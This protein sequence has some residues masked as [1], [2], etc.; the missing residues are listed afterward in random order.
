MRNVL[1][2]VVAAYAVMVSASLAN[3][4]LVNFEALARD[5]TAWS[6]NVI[7]GEFPEQYGSLRLSETSSFQQNS[8]PPLTTSTSLNGS[9]AGLASLTL[10]NFELAASGYFVSRSSGLNIP[11]TL[12]VLGDISGI[13]DQSGLIPDFFVVDYKEVEK[14]IAPQTLFNFTA[15]E[16]GIGFESFSITV[17]FLVADVTNNGLAAEFY[18]EVNFSRKMSF[19][20]TAGI[21]LALTGIAIASLCGLWYARRTKTTRSATGGRV[22]K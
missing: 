17:P 1:P 6:T 22:D 14:N 3:A 15:L 20:S 4:A 13:A 11:G 5:T 21:T 12:T 7:L 8:S 16:A 18:T 19:L 10:S 9:E 2:A